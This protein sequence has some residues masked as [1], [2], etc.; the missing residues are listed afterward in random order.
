[1]R[2]ICESI[3]IAIDWKQCYTFLWWNIYINWNAT[4]LVVSYIEQTTEQRFNP[5]WTSLYSEHNGKRILIKEH[6]SVVRALTLRYP[7]ERITIKLAKAFWYE[8]ILR[9][10]EYIHTTWVRQRFHVR[11]IN[12]RDIWF[13]QF[14][15]APKL[16]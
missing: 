1:M 16:R 2:M 10:I 9:T 3:T 11:V 13:N 14:M 12:N 4:F 8:I 15:C 5:I 7:L 6:G